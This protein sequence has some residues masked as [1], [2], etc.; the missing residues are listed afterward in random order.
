MADIGGAVVYIVEPG[1]YSGASLADDAANTAG[2]TYLISYISKLK[3][4]TVYL[5]VGTLSHLIGRVSGLFGVIWL[6]GSASCVF[7]CVFRMLD[8]FI[9]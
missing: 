9:G 2:S 6:F 4:Y 7:I 3:R 1:S 8:G 5:G